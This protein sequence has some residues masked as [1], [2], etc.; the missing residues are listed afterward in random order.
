M[1]KNKTQK[2]TEIMLLKKKK[3]YEESKTGKKE[4]N[5]Y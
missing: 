2:K 4:H 1:K 3:V 5:S